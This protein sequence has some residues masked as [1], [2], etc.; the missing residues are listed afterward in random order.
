MKI[1]LF[2]NYDE[3]T[4]LQQYGSAVSGNRAYVAITIVAVFSRTF[5]ILCN[6][7]YIQ[8]INQSRKDFGMLVRERISTIAH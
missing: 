3:K 1:S 2:T 4:D 6:M 8:T 5:Q 7:I